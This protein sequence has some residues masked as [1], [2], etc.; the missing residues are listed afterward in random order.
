MTPEEIVRCI[1]FRYIT[2]ALTPD[3]ALT[4]LRR[5]EPTR[6]QREAEILATGLSARLLSW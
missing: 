5:L 1:P 2:D 4:I 6:G 3:E